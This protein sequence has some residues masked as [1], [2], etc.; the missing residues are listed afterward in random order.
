MTHWP[1][2]E[3]IYFPAAALL[4]F[5]GYS[6]GAAFDFSP[7]RSRFTHL[8]AACPCSRAASRATHPTHMNRD[9]RH[10]SD[11][12]PRPRRGHMREPRGPGRGVS[13]VRNGLVP[14]IGMT[15]K[16]ETDVPEPWRIRIL[17]RRLTHLFLPAAILGVGLCDRLVGSSFRSRLLFPLPSLRGSARRASATLSRSSCQ[18]FDLASCICGTIRLCCFQPLSIF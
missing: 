5:A 18:S 6:Q 1:K 17:R 11:A 7:N 14:S 2:C 8:H 4:G 13:V 12:T 15:P 16:K 9:P 3:A 10:L